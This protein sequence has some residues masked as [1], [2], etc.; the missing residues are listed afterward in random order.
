MKEGEEGRRRAR[1]EEEENQWRCR[2]Q[3]VGVA[4]DATMN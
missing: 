3:R 1:E 2:R 4:I